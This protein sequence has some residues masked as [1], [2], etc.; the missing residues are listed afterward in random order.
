MNAPVKNPGQGGFTLLELLI[1]TVVF[2]LICGAIFGLL[3]MA[4]KNYGRETQIS[5]SFQEARL[6]V[7]QIVADFDQAGYPS[8]PCFQ[9]F[10]PRRRMP[11]VR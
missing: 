5:S 8:S 4:Q 6:A 2:L 11:M 3:D 9:K 1:A 10:R 7:D